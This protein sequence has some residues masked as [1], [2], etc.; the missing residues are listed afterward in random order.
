M[1]LSLGVNFALIGQLRTPQPLIP[2]SR[3]LAPAEQEGTYK[4]GQALEAACAATA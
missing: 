2:T 4:P 3:Q 1:S